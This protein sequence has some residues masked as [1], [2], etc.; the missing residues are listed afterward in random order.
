M[1]TVINIKEENNMKKQLVAG[2]V[3]LGVIG[4]STSAFADY[5]YTVKSG[6]TFWKIADKT[7]TGIDE[8]IS[9]NPQV[10]NINMIYPNQKLTIPT[11]D[12]ASQSYEQQVI[13]LVNK[14]RQKAGLKPLKENWELSRVARFKSQDMHDKGYFDHNSPTYGSPF[15]MIKDFGISYNYAGENIAYGQRTP[16]E[17]MKAWMNSSGHRA[18]ILSPNFTQIGVGYVKDGNY[19]T[20]QF[21]SQ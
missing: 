20:Q 9:A 3:A 6:D 4:A 8:I 11:L 1:I 19:W 10:K 2:L 17:V 5:D 7:H 14:E 18:N 13:S 12:Q 21:I 16:E 15:K